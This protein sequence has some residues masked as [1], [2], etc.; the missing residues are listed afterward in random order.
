M[1]EFCLGFNLRERHPGRTPDNENVPTDKVAL[2]YPNSYGCPGRGGGHQIP[3]HDGPVLAIQKH[4]QRVSDLRSNAH[5][6][7]SVDAEPR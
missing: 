1:A 4:D 3:I 7:T 5:R 2:R 6:R